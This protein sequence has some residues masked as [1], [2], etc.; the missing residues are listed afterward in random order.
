MNK[1]FY[2]K[3]LML[4]FIFAS[5]SALADGKALVGENVKDGCNPANWT[6]DSQCQMKKA[7]ECGLNTAEF[8]R[9]DFPVARKNKSGK[10]TGSSAVG[11]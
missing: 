3:V 6:C 2:M 4:L 10:G 5:F 7:S 11:Q 9:K 8:E 1:E